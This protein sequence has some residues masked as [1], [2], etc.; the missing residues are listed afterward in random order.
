MSERAVYIDS[1]AYRPHHKSSDLLPLVAAVAL[2]GTVAGYCGID[3][4][5]ST[6]PEAS[7]TPLSS[8]APDLASILRKNA[9]P[10]AVREHIGIATPEEDSLT[11][12]ILQRKGRGLEIKYLRYAT[13]VAGRVIPASG[14]YGKALPSEIE[15]EHRLE[16]PLLNIRAGEEHIWQDEIEIKS[17][18][19]DLLVDLQNWL[20]S[21]NKKG[22]DRLRWAIDKAKGVRRF[23]AINFFEDF[24]IRQNQEH[25]TTLEI[26]L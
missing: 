4:L 6:P 25:K 23:A 16:N 19:E 11:F 17:K 2:V 13:P 3:Y 12:W 9:L 24:F 26:K 7:A 8:Q 20:K 1:H 10:I 18:S 21:I 22:S 15:G 14:L 5:K